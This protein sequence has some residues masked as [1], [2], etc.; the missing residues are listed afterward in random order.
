[1]FAECSGDASAFIAI[2]V[3][4]Y[5]QAIHPEEVVLVAKAF[6]HPDLLVAGVRWTISGGAGGIA[7][8]RLRGRPTSGIVLVGGHG[9]CLVIGLERVGGIEIRSQHGVLVE[10]G[11]VEGR[12]LIV[13]L[14]EVVTL[15]DLTALDEV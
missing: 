1:M 11:V 13:S 4:I 3:L 7:I 15:D 12:L 5:A 10:L 9:E 6:L 8:L 2:L 14:Y